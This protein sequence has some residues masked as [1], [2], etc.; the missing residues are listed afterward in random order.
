MDIPETE[1][2]SLLGKEDLSSQAIKDSGGS[3]IQHVLDFVEDHG[4]KRAEDGFN[5]STFTFGVLNCFLIIHIFGAYPQH[6]WILYLLESAY[7]FPLRTMQLV[8]AVPN[9]IYYYTDLCWV[10]NFFGVIILLVLIFGRSFLSRELIKLSYVAFFGMG[11]GP[12]LGSNIV[13]DFVSLTFH[14]T[15]SM[16]SVFIHIY[17]PLLLYV[18][19]W[20]GDAI[21]AAWPEYFKL[22]YEND[23]FPSAE[24]SFVNSVFGAT[25]SL[26][27]LWFVMQTGWQLL[28]GLDLPKYGYDTCYHNNMRGGGCTVLGNIFW[29]RP[30]EVS[31]EQ[32]KTNNFEMR[33]FLVYQ[34]LHALAFFVSLLSCG[35]LCNL[36]HYSHGALLIMSLIC[37]TLRGGKRYTYYS[38][39]MYT[40]LIQRQFAS[41]LQK[42]AS[43]KGDKK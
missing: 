23:F 24:V 4:N 14:D 11:C 16:T 29:K 36:S 1:K 3:T 22:Q 34:I 40:K 9:K 26:Y 7:F 5:A 19:R 30:V 38:T 33:D 10:M 27:M 39:T 41:D 12:L 6:F 43:S 37:T 31:K 42:V 32:M 8:R 18:F 35:Y 2:S 13:F 21:R 15:T 17:P 25:T 28:V 20:Q